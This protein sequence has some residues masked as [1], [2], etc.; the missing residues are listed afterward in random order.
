M[1]KC[2]VKNFKAK[3]VI[4]ARLDNRTN[5]NLLNLINSLS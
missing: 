4:Y 5:E 1:Y 2:N 3:Q